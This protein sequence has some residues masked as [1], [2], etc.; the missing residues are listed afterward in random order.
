MHNNH[1]WLVTAKAL[2]TFHR[3]VRECDTSFQDEMLHCA[4]TAGRHRLLRMDNYRDVMSNDTWDV[5]TWVRVYSTYLDERLTV[6]KVLRCDF[7]GH[8]DAQPVAEKIADAPPAELF[9]IAR[10]LQRLVDALYNCIPEGSA[11]QHA[12]CVASSNLA[13]K[14]FPQAYNAMHDTTLLVA[15]RV[16][17]LSRPSEASEGLEIVRKANDLYARVAGFKSRV[18]GVRDVGRGV[19]IADVPPPPGEAISVLEE[20]V[21]SLTAKPSKSGAKPI[22]MPVLPKAIGK[23]S[24]PYAKVEVRASEATKSE[25]NLLADLD[26]LAPEPVKPTI[27]APPTDPFGIETIDMFSDLPASPE[28][29]PADPIGGP[30]TPVPLQAPAGHPFAGKCMFVSDPFS[31]PSPVGFASVPFCSPA[32]AATPSTMSE[33]SAMSTFNTPAS[34]NFS[35]MPTTPTPQPSQGHSIM[36]M[37]D[38]FGAS[39]PIPEPVTPQ[40]APM[41]SP[42]NGFSATPLP[43]TNSNP[44]GS[45]LTSSTYYS[46]PQAMNNNNPFGAGA[47]LHQTPGTPSSSALAAAGLSPTMVASAMAKT[48]VHDPFADLTSSLKPAR[49]N[50][51]AGNNRPMRA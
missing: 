21:A 33:F 34:S 26:D 31:S 43:A 10:A 4:E 42:A 37:D 41:A 11:K 27:H 15:E 51:L 6:Y 50:P 1:G 29:A 36:L 48:S 19:R 14:E 28:P 22:S 8:A 39:A 9:D 18:E 5:S 35:S 3:L 46:L 13:A 44:F 17:E 45:A 40:L 47:G 12:V 32:P 7:D 16:L 2:M 30:Q 24:V 49:P 38:L 20:H 23:A 25:P